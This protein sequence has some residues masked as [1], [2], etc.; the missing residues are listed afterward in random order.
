M[1]LRAVCQAV[2]GQA[3]QVAWRRRL[4]TTHVD[5]QLIPVSGFGATLSG[6][7]RYANYLSGL[8]ASTALFWPHSQYPLWQQLARARMAFCSPGCLPTALQCVSANGYRCQV[9][10]TCHTKHHLPYTSQLRSALVRSW[11]TRAAFF[12]DATLRTVLLNGITTKG[13][14]A[15]SGRFGFDWQEVRGQI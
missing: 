11:C 10:C 14:A 12:A 4:D 15:L 8:S 6:K 3:G 1:P 7:E 2:R 13:S 9:R 5:R